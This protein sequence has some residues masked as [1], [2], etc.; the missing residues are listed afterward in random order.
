MPKKNGPVEWKIRNIMADGTILE[1][2][3]KFPITP[4]LLAAFGEAAEIVRRVTGTVVFDD[5]STQA[6]SKTIS[7]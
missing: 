2:G 4:E 5:N 1:P 6:K 3:Q 7:A